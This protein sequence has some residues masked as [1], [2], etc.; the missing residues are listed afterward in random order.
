VNASFLWKGEKWAFWLGGILFWIGTVCAMIAA[1]HATI[2]GDPIDLHFMGEVANLLAASSAAA[3]L[4]LFLARRQAEGQA[5]AKL[6]GKY[7]GRT[8]DV[9][10]NRG[11]AALLKAGESWSS[12]QAA[13]GCSRATVAKIAKR[14]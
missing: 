14:A 7:R 13:F 11:I 9:E 6:D 1:K 3:T 12:I 2:D 5:K 10:R 8:E 4:L